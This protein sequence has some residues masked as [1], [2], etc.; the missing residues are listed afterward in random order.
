MLSFGQDG[1]TVAPPDVVT[2]TLRKLGLYNR[3]FGR[4]S[5]PPL[6]MS[7]SKSVLGPQ[8]YRPSLTRAA[9]PLS[10]RHYAVEKARAS[11]A[12]HSG[13]VVVTWSPPPHV[14]ITAGARGL[15]ESPPNLSMMSSS[16]CKPLRSL[17]GSHGTSGEFT[18]EN[19]SIGPVTRYLC[20]LS[21][22]SWSW[23]NLIVWFVVFLE[24]LQFGSLACSAQT[25][26][27]VQLLQAVPPSIRSFLL[28]AQAILFQASLVST[29]QLTP[30]E[31]GFWTVTTFGIVYAALCGLFIALDLTA[32]SWLS[33]ILFGLLAG[34]G[35]VSVTSAAFFV[36][37]NSSDTGHIVVCFLILLYYSSTA[38][39]VSVYRGD[40]ANPDGTEIRVVPRFLAVER[41]LKGLLSVVF[42]ALEPWP[43]LRSWSLV[44]FYSA[45]LAYYVRVSPSN[46][47]GL[48]IVRGT[49]LT[50]VWWLSLV[51]AVAMELGA[52]STWES[53]ESLRTILA[54]GITFIVI[55]GLSLLLPSVN[56]CRCGYRNDMRH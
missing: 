42:L 38:V 20:K 52:S 13:L 51:G 45:F 54:V 39:F 47:I 6:V 23:R 46:S 7:A 53:L 18:T 4:R 11:P 40:A 17:S 15:V 34:G 3:C 26:G 14:E 31:F 25:G 55:V 36:V 56:A 12:V 41:V 16:T 1:S 5:T 50:V 43:N 2:G 24:L 27:G 29:P 49:S 37:L 33:P 44:V 35:F 8:F 19:P 21:F 10:S 32:D 9:T 48:N 28:S 22:P 30:L